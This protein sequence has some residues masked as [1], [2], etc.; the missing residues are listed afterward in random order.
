MQ[1]YKLEKIMT[2]FNLIIAVRRFILLMSVFM[3]IVSTP[4]VM[5]ET[6]N[7]QSSASVL[8]IFS[9]KIDQSPSITTELSAVINS[10]SH[11]YLAHA[12]FSNRADDLAA[13]YKC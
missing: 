8:D 13:L 2:R 3:I 1:L 7:D 10:K 5:A 9:S 11:P 12:D 4:I 6:Q